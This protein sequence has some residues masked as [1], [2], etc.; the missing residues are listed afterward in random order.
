MSQNMGDIEQGATS[1]STT[2]PEDVLASAAHSDDDEKPLNSSDTESDDEYVL[3]M[4][5]MD[6]GSR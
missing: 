3:I 6:G 5:C 2:D 4:D 1:P